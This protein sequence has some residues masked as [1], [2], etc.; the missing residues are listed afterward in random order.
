MCLQT[1]LT[2][3]MTGNHKLLTG[4]LKYALNIRVTLIIIKKGA[5]V[6]ACITVASR[7]EKVKSTLAFK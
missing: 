3:D 5:K 1:F 2:L 6:R 7:I 4:R